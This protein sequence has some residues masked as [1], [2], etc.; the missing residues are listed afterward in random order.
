[1][2]VENLVFNVKYTGDAAGRSTDKLGKSLTKLQGASKSA[3]KGLGSLMHVLKGLTGLM[4]LHS[5][6]RSIGKA[7]KEGLENAYKYSSVMSGEMAAALDRLKSASVQATGAFGSAFGELLATLSPILISILN[8]ITRV[9]D[10][11]AQLFAVLGGRSTYT[12]AV[13]SSE[14]WADATAKGAKSAKEWKNQLLGFDEI[15]RLED[16]SSNNG[17]SGST[18]PYSGAFETAPA[19]NEWARQLREIT[20]TWLQTVNFEPLINA[21]GRLKEAVSGFV[22]IVNNGLRWAYENVLLPLAKW[23]IEKNYPA[24]INMIATAFEFL[25]AVLIKL[26]PLLL[27]IWNNILKPVAN[28]MGTVLLSAVNYVTTALEGLAKKVTDARSFSEFLKS[29]NGKEALLLGIA[30][31][32]AAIIANAMMFKTVNS[33]MS[34]SKIAF[35]A[36]TSPIGLVAAGIAGL[37]TVGVALYQNWDDIKKQVAELKQKFNDMLST[38]TSGIRAFGQIIMDNC[39]HV[40]ELIQLVVNLFQRAR[41]AVLQLNE[42]I[43]A[44]ASANAQRIQEDGSIYLQGFASGGFPSEGE[45]FMARENG[46]PEMVGRIGNRTAVANNDQIVQAISTGV[47]NAVVSGMSMM[48]G[49]NDK[50]VRIYLDGKEVARSTTR[51]QRQFARAGTM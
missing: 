27:S 14:R 32:I 15:N 50:D 45:L 17:G 13:A 9:A 3:N 47:F 39:P 22:S 25:N 30:S 36:L 42:V 24:Q 46:L 18:S 8:L 41:E 7:M 20:S 5:I 6:I 29:L 33:L 12:K 43:K 51:Y 11:I 40:V 21:W 35:T 48:G 38:F 44:K 49:N 1:M 31:A 34:V 37:V 28:F 23:E 26:Q 10:A 19:I 4:G 2:E 16:Q